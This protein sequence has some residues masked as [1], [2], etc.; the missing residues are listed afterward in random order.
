MAA[1][2]AVA[3]G[4]LLARVWPLVERA[5]TEAALGAK[6]AAVEELLVERHQSDA[7]RQAAA[8][9][10]T[11]IT[12]ESDRRRRLYETILSSTPD[13]IYVFDLHKRFTYANAA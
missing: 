1:A 6:L 4:D 7:K 12:A 8:D 11:R 13:Q 3:I 9:L 5:R 2:R 10:V